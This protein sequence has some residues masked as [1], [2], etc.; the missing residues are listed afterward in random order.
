MFQFP[1]NS[2]PPPPPSSSPCDI[3]QKGLKGKLQVFM[4]S[5]P[6]DSGP[7]T[8]R[9]QARLHFPPPAL[10]I[11]FTYQRTGLYKLQE[12]TKDKIKLVF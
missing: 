11:P 9:C 2:P 7:P 1:P 5:V 6:A 4:E 10:R 3:N 8:L 12:I